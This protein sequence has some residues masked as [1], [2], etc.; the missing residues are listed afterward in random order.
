VL[1]RGTR[2]RYPKNETR[3]REN[4]RPSEGWRK[5]EMKKREDGPS[6]GG[7]KMGNIGEEGGS[8][9]GRRDMIRV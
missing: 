2:A 4:P 6:R 8:R 3:H 5:S 1:K 9:I 7:K